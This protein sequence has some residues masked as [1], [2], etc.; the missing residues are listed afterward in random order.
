M[1]CKACIVALALAFGSSNCDAIQCTVGTQGVAFGAYDPFVNQYLDG[2]GNI[3]VACDVLTPYTLALSSG[4]GPYSS[5]TMIGGADVLR[6]N[7]FTDPARTTVWGDGA[8]ST[9]TVGASAMIGNHTVYGRIP[10]RQN[11]RPGTYV[12]A[13]IVL[14]NF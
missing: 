13:I 4:N 5:R 12:D 8:G 9:A 7:L 6:Y 10:A 1:R 11:V 2:T 14:V 3:S